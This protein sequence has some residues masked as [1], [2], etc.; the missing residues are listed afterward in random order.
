MKRHCGVCR[1]YVPDKDSI[2]GDGWCY[3]DPPIPIP[4][5]GKDCNYVDAILP[6]VWESGWCGRWGRKGWWT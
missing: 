6:P 4:R 2:D 3:F 5:E 1:Y